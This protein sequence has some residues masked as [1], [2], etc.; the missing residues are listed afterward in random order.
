M[1][2]IIVLLFF[3]YLL[4]LGLF[5]V[6]WRRSIKYQTKNS[7][8]VEPLLSIIIPARNEE[9]RIGELLQNILEQTYETF[10][11]LVVDDH[12]TDNTTEVVGRYAN[13]PNVRLVPNHGEGKKLALAT[14][15]AISKGK[16]IV[17]TDA[18]C[19]VGKDWLRTLAR[20]F[21]DDSTKMVFGGV[22][23]RV[24][25]FFSML[26]AHEFLS[27]IG[28]A[29]GTL[30]WGLPSMCNG[31]NLAF[32]KT[33][34]EETGGYASNL[35]I[36]SGDDEF[37]ML[38]IAKAYPDGIKFL[39]DQN[40]VVETYPA[41]TLRD[42]INQRIRWAGKFRHNLSVPNIALAIFIFCFHVSVLALLVGMGIG[43]INVFSGSVL[44]L[45]KITFEWIFLTRVATFLS[46]RWNVAAF[47]V[48]QV[49]Y[50]IYAI[51]IGV[52]SIFRSYHWKGRKLKSIAI[53]SIKNKSLEYKDL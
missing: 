2:I 34:F 3:L 17:T 46:V 7:L 51:S 23:I 39:S 45:S 20:Y 18:D 35:H 13:H 52:M 24:H 9:E 32:R 30:A 10:E 37:L 47:I 27:L 53:H 50:P 48:L 5:I 40:A 41:N 31:A 21:A 16:I 49:I 6:G 29:A 36:P 28:T 44:L 15:I 43:R 11:V 8:N 33:V 22:R 25:N 19:R 26:Q 1:T 38:N 14:G 4:F 42:F 12:S